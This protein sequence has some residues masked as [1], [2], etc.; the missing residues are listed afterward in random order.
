[1][2]GI[3]LAHVCVSIPLFVGLHGSRCAFALDCWPCVQ[4]SGQLYVN[5]VIPPQ[6]TTP[7]LKM[8]LLELSALLVLAR[9]LC[10]RCFFFSFFFC[11]SQN[12]FGLILNGFQTSAPSFILKRLA[13]VVLPSSNV[14]CFNAEVHKY[15][16]TETSISEGCQF[17]IMETNFISIPLLI[18]KHV[19]RFAVTVE[20]CKIPLCD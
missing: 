4:A 9:W 5:P 8:D 10:C 13:C 14:R 7:G 3:P 20:V 2:G 19:T 15:K 1:M 12:W 6:Q 17:W 16:K 18:P 11:N